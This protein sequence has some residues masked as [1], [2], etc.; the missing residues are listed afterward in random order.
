[1]TTEHAGG[2]VVTLGSD[3]GSRHGCPHDSSSHECT[4]PAAV[5][6]ASAVAVA[7]VHIDVHVDIPV[8]VDIAVD[9][10]VHVRIPVDV[11]IAVHVI[12]PVDVRPRRTANVASIP[13]RQHRGVGEA[14]CEAG[15]ECEPEDARE[16][17]RLSGHGQL[18]PT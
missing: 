5:V 1:M 12:V 15:H 4:R 3:N 13:L 17:C 8:H 10:P 6:A 9:V 18:L 16:A 2:S 14:E 7:M 11:V